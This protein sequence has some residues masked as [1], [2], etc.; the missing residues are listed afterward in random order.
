ML[1]SLI[2]QPDTHSLTLELLLSRIDMDQFNLFASVSHPTGEHKMLG[3]A[4]KHRRR[5]AGRV[6]LLVESKAVG[7]QRTKDSVEE[8]GMSL[9]QAQ[10]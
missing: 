6:A 8:A 9:R 4:G 10:V 1:S 2:F 3:G 7:R 5:Y